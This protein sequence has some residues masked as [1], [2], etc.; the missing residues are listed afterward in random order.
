MSGLGGC[1]KMVFMRFVL[2]LSLTLSITCLLT[3]ALG[4]S[5]DA[6]P[7]VPP[8]D[9]GPHET[10]R[11]PDGK[12]THSDGDPDGPSTP[13]AYVNADDWDEDG[14]S[15]D[16][17][18]KLGTDPH[19]PDTDND[20]K[21]DGDEN[22]DTDGDGKIDALEP[23]DFDSDMDGKMDVDDPDDTDGPCGK[24][25]RIFDRVLQTQ[26][27][28]LSDTTC[29]PYKVLGY[30]WLDGGAKLTIN[31]GIKVTFGK[32]AMLRIGSTTTTAALDLA[33]TKNLQTGTIKWVKLVADTN[34][35]TKGYW[36]GVVVDNGTSVSIAYTQIDHAGGKTGGADA[37]AHVLIKAADSI[38]FKGNAL[39][40]GGGV[41][42]HAAV[43]KTSQ[44]KLFTSLTQ[45]TF[46]DLVKAAALNIASLGE[47]GSNN[48]FGGYDV[49]V[50]EGSV[51]T[52]ATWRDV[53][54]SPYVFKEASINVDAQL[55]IE[56]GVKLI[57]PQNAAFSV[58][59]STLT[60]GQL[61]AQG[62]QGSP[63]IFTAAT[64]KS[65]QGIILYANKN[66]LKHVQVIRGGLVN[67]T[68][69]GSSVYLDKSATLNADSITIQDSAAYGVYYYRS[70]SGCTG[71]NTTDFSFQGAITACKFYCLDDYNSGVC[72]TP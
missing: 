39:S 28:T 23:S 43:L 47:I 21:K 45:N 67:S 64:G 4:C 34:V 7:V 57:F 54:L 30:L 71:Q 51:T 14:I 40:H 31:A 20:G 15:N 65:W 41:G 2:R 36:R 60:T 50:H 12:V 66:Q 16:D 1:G 10:I 72:L 8:V 38:Y 9:A 3:L 5:D 13:D 42:L 26:D 46:S 62:S 6:A 44:T 58:G 49:E 29:S 53:G 24:V 70:L 35:P 17:E 33:G 27:L 55:K 68:G 22:K 32:N 37:Q 52:Q 48:V 59:T 69:V 19:N 18:K 25:K 56:S 63:V 11:F 61:E